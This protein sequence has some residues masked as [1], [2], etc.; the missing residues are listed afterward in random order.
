M[1][2]IL[3]RVKSGNVTEKFFF[4]IFMNFTKFLVDRN[5]KPVKRFLPHVKP[6]DIEN[7]ILSLLS[8]LSSVKTDKVEL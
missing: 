1:Y 6:E 2:H 7:D 8:T 4:S 5:G 3:C